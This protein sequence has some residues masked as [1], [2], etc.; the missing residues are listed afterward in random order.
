VEPIKNFIRA[1]R[2]IRGFE[3]LTEIDEEISADADFYRLDRTGSIGGR[4]FLVMA[5]R[6]ALD[7]LLRLW[8]EYKAN[9]RRRFDRGFGPW[10]VLFARLKT[11]RLWGTE[12]RLRDTGLLDIWRDEL[13]NGRERV[14]FEAELWFRG[15]ELERQRATVAVQQAI[16][17]LGGGVIQTAVFPQ[18]SYH[19]MLGSVPAATATQILEGGLVRLLQLDQV[20]F[21]RPSGQ[22]VATPIEGED[23]VSADQTPTEPPASG[24]PRVGLLD[25]L[26]LANHELLSGR[27]LLDDPL[28]WEKDYQAGERC[29][30]TAMA[31]LIV[32]GD[33]SSSEGPIARPVY[34]RPIMRPNPL[35]FRTP[36][37][38]SMPEG[39]LAVD[40]LHSAVRRI[41]EGEGGERAVAPSVRVLNLS[42]GNAS[43]P[44]EGIMSP[45][46]R[47]VDW[48]S[49]KYKVL[50]MVSAGND[51]NSLRLDVANVDI[52]RLDI[53]GLASAVSRAV[54]ARAHLS[55]ILSP[56]ESVNALT[57]GSLHDDDSELPK[58][59][60]LIDPY[61]A[62][63][64]PSPVNR[65]GL[66]FKRA[67]KPDV[68]LSGG[69]QL[70]RLAISP[71][72]PNG[73][74]ELA[75]TSRTGPGQ[76]TAAPGRAGELGARRFMCGTSNATA[77][78]THSCDHILEMLEQMEVPW[79]QEQL[80][81]LTKTLLVHGSAWTEAA[82]ALRQAL[83]LGD[84]YRDH[85]CR[86]FGYGSVDLERVLGCEENRVTVI[87]AG[88]IDEDKGH[89]YHLPLPPSLSGLIGLRKLTVSLAWLTPVNAQHRDYRRAALWVSELDSDRELRIK[90]AYVDWQSALRGT[91]QH[92]IFEGRE[93]IPL[94]DGDA[95]R[96]K[97]NCRA[98]AGPLGISI[99][100][101]LVVTFE[102]SDELRVPVYTEVAERIT[103]QGKVFAK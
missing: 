76:L 59:I 61:P 70:F 26:P 11:L 89:I 81:V 41:Y 39:Q 94:V 27:L 40:L 35:D 69:Q 5:N 12:D 16:G 10:K 78:G 75:G 79:S 77:L 91:I 95:V 101:A 60:G 14:T 96:I 84:D 21:F 86:Y 9:P 93:A 23:Q 2:P 54:H 8:S 73:I 17:D 48:L 42:I 58:P 3:W 63:G 103:T 50:F 31:S 57:V 74:L 13:E 38:E 47:M 6:A 24:L 87:S 22:A 1:V 37:I 25:G 62:T 20:M 65:V 49:W 88:H 36:R 33:L 72:D 102:T 28:E 53:D 7:V 82:A 66:G 29:H 30:G 83:Q 4:L 56:S 18:I 51:L 55:R 97:V 46:A 92:E 67:I 68:L 80:A 85:I 99:P 52:P 34:V 44:L 15:S 98:D 43:L 19:G 45:F 90:R 32:R 71:G 64:Y 100:Y